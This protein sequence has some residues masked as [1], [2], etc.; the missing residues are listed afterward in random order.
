MRFRAN[1][2]RLYSTAGKRPF[3]SGEG[4]GGR[5]SSSPTALT[6]FATQ[7]LVDRF[8]QQDKPL[9][10]HFDPL[11]SQHVYPVETVAVSDPLDNHFVPLD[12]KLNSVVPRCGCGN[13]PPSR[14]ATASHRSRRASFPA[15]FTTLAIR[16]HDVGQRAELLRRRPLVVGHSGHDMIMTTFRRP[17]ILKASRSVARSPFAVRAARDFVQAMGLAT[18]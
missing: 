14:P 2:I 10:R 15:R 5:T 3:A 4:S 13:V 18:R 9:P 7:S 8:F 12:S 16:Q 1:D 6:R 17:S 11:Q